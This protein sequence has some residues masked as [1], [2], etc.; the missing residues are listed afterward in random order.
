[1][2][3]LLLPTP[4]SGGIILSYKCNA[5]CRHCI[6]ASSPHW[7][8]NWM[9]EKELHILLKILKGK[10][11]PSP[12]GKDRIGANYGLHFTGGEPFLNFPLLLKAVELAEKAGI[13]S[14]FVETNAFWAREDEKTF[15]I[16]KELKE[17]GLKGILISVNPF[18]VEYVP[19]QR[20]ERAVRIGYE[21]FR[22][23]LIVY[24]WE[25][26][27][28]F[29]NWGIKGRLNWDEYVK[30]K[31]AIIGELLLMGRAVYKLSGWRRFKPSNFPGSCYSELTR[32]WHNHWDNYGNI[33]PGFCAGL[34]L[35][36][37][38][39]NPEIYEKGIDLE[40]RPVLKIL[41]EEGVR[42]L[43]DWAKRKF[44][45]KEKE[46]YFSPCHLCLDIRKFLVEKGETFPELAPT[47]YYF[48][49]EE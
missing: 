43:L 48:R 3:T 49:V 28:L 17:R 38:K 25:Y 23:N 37:W 47:E 14:L 32:T 30:K 42:G 4:I 41:L 19:F 9:E 40:K 34:S 29:K 2:S 7:E 12:Y 27:L 44:N 13:P 45:F 20:I 11:Q 1:M 18:I 16:L 36:N 22:E 10:I 21:V 35:G 33:I 8:R 6:Y 26:F 46:G 24:Q 31:E 15:K 5:Q 39:E